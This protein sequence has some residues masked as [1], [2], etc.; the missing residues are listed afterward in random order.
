M[1]GHSR[2]ATTLKFY[3]KYIQDDSKRHALFLN[4]ERTV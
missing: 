3:G 1:L 4:D 2:V